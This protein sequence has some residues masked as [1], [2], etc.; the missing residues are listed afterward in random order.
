MYLYLIRHGIA[1]NLDT[2]DADLTMSDSARPLT[3]TGRKK[4]QQVAK[5]LHKCGLEFD[6][7]FTSP[8]VRAQATADILIDHKLSSQL[9]VSQDL[10]P[11][12][13]LES[14]MAWWGVRANQNPISNLA[15]V[16]HEPNLSEWAELLIFGNIQHRL[17][18]KKGGVIGLQFPEDKI[19]IGAAQLYCLIPPKYLS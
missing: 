3:K 8:L 10:A 9:E 4:M 12:G 5:N 1:V 13:T 17:I 14:W 15:L 16:G 7:I 2:I 6:R 11:A 19:E 18:L